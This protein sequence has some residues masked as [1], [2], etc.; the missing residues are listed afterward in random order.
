LEVEPLPSSPRLIANQRQRLC[1]RHHFGVADL[2][3]LSRPLDGEMADSLRVSAPVS[4]HV[5]RE[6]DVDPASTSR[7]TNG[8]RYPGP[9][10]RP[11]S[12]AMV[13]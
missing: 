12:G 6:L 3:D 1:R 9:E 5:M 8:V 7:T 13:R 10:R 4:I 2:E 11:T